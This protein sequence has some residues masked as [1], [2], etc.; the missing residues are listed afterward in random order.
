MTSQRTDKT[1][2]NFSCFNYDITKSYL[3]FLFRVKPERPDPRDLKEKRANKATKAKKDPRA[4][5]ARKVTR[6]TKVRRGHQERTVSTVWTDKRE[7]KAK[8]DPKVNP[9][10]ESR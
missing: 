6:V 7:L 2:I 1:S 8:K 5:K 10:S 3:S 9:V 4:P